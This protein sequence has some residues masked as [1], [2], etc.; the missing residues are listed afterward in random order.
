MLV[1]IRWVWFCCIC[2]CVCECAN[3]IKLLLDT[4]FNLVKFLFEIHTFLIFHPRIVFASL[5]FVFF[6]VFIF[7]FVYFIYHV[8]IS[9]SSKQ[10]RFE[11]TRLTLRIHRGRRA[12]SVPRV[13]PPFTGSHLK[14]SKSVETTSLDR[15]RKCATPKS[16]VM[17]TDQLKTEDCAT[18]IASK[19]PIL[20]MMQITL[21][22]KEN[23]ESFLCNTQSTDNA[24]DATSAPSPCATDGSKTMKGVG[25]RILKVQ[26]KRFRME[27]KAA[28]TLAIIVGGF[29]VCWLPF[30]TMYMI[31]A[32]CQL[33]IQPLLF[34]VLFWLG[35]CNSAINPLIYA[36]FSKEFRIAFKTILYKCLCV[37]CSNR[38]NEL[39]H[40]NLI[41]N[42]NTNSADG[43]RW[44][45]STSSSAKSNKS[46]GIR[47]ISRKSKRCPPPQSLI[48]QQSQAQTVT[49]TI[50]VFDLTEPDSI[51]IQNSSSCV[52]TNIWNI[53]GGTNPQ[54]RLHSRQMTAIRSEHTFKGKRNEGKFV[55]ES[56]A[57]ISNPIIIYINSSFYDI[58]SRYIRRMKRR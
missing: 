31:R 42:N 6:D 27:T 56:T 19:S 44:R 45:Q 25:K 35:Y 55:E 13:S 33:C 15:R 58:L 50:V 40:K 3:H 32:F 37:H 17:R 7:D 47:S 23:M 54:S 22:R 46:F 36:L 12:N 5:R 34:S 43:S 16:A 38:T 49:P 52:Q 53:M 29:I 28:K 51:V 30:F 20:H 4:I 1:A 21:N 41:H 24:C 18:E 48:P 57:Q 9:G 10:N 26:A 14:P 2:F 11:E 8:D 39:T